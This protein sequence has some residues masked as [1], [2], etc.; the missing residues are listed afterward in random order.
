MNG[1]QG[2]HEKSKEKM[3][4][5]QLS[6]KEENPP[7]NHSALGIDSPRS[8][9]PNDINLGDLVHVD[10]TNVTGQLPLGEVDTV[11]QNNLFFII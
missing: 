9:D 7:K 8:S 6:V 4:E 5:T 1:K 2:G 11:R 10:L 3:D